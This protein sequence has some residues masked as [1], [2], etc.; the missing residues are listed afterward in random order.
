MLF[1]AFSSE[2]KFPSNLIQWDD[3]RG[4]LNSLQ[5]GCNHRRSWAMGVKLFAKSQ[6]SLHF[7]EKVDGKRLVRKV[8]PLCHLL[9]ENTTRKKLQVHTKVFYSTE[10]VIKNLILRILFHCWIPTTMSSQNIIH[11]IF[12]RLFV[13]NFHGGKHFDFSSFFLGAAI[14]SI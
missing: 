2:A 9:T 1:K 13:K 6:L 10:K 7:T 14:F 3:E 5:L 4:I 12:L 8:F 11:K